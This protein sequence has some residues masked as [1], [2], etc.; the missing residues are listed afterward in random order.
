MAKKIIIL[1]FITLNIFAQSTE[2]GSAEFS[3]VGTKYSF[4]NLSYIFGNSWFGIGSAIGDIYS[5]NKQIPFFR[6]KYD[7]F[8]NQYIKDTVSNKYSLYTFFPLKLTFIPFAKSD[9]YGNEKLLKYFLQF[10]VSFCPWT[11]LGVKDISYR[12][13]PR[14]ISLTDV[15]LSLYYG[16]KFIY[17]FVRYG[18]LIYSI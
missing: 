9:D 3:K 4:L 6:E 13:D 17:F 5:F 18:Q 11:T 15:N 8:W 12:D 10:S 16:W 1:T 2:L 14:N 7:Y